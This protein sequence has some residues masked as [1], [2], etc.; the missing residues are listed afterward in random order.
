MCIRDRDISER[1][2]RL[3]KNAV[4]HIK[5]DTGMSRLGFLISEESADTIARITELP[6]IEAEGIFTHFRCV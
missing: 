6:G 5:L 1:A 3:E 4:I 2:Q